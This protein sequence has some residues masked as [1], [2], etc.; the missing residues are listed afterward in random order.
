MADRQKWQI[1]KIT[2]QYTK[3]NN[4]SPLKSIKYFF[5]LNS[6]SYQKCQT[7]YL[8]IFK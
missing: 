4:F 5:I 6:T 7:F 2:N 3:T 8:K 1:L